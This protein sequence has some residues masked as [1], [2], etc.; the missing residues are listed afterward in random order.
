MNGSPP[1]RARG[2]RTLLMVAA[3]FLLPVAV[4]FRLY[5][6]RVWR[7]AGNSAMGELIQPAR[8]LRSPAEPCRRQSAGADVF[9][10]KWSLIYIGDGGCDDACRTALVFGR[11]S[12]SR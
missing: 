3:V 10:G 11:Q 7:P 6:G 2:R 4:V 5:Y 9:P 8:P 12:V 1:E